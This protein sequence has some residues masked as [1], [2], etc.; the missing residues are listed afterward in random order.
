MKKLQKTL[1][2]F[3]AAFVASSF[4]FGGSASAM[5][6]NAPMYHEL[7]NSSGNSSARTNQN[8]DE[9]IIRIVSAN[10]VQNANNQN[11]QNVN[12]QNSRNANDPSSRNANSE[13]NRNANDQNSQN[14]NSE[15]NQNANNQSSRNANDGVIQIVNANS[16]Q[17]SDDDE[18]AHTGVMRIVRANSD[19]DANSENSRDLNMNHSQGLRMRNAQIAPILT[20]LRPFWNRLKQAISPALK[21]MLDP[22]SKKVVHP[23]A[24]VAPPIAGGPQPSAGGPPP[25]GSGSDKVIKNTG[26]GADCFAIGSAVVAAGISGAA[27]LGYAILVRKKKYV[28]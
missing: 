18:D 17:D 13:N 24:M 8:L 25:R 1:S 4:C 19:Q 2:L 9:G 16:A 20:V 10:D 3:T 14:A 15:N 22:L 11:N 21:Q 28:K 23:A 5:L 7:V 26:L 12:N 6:G 27:G